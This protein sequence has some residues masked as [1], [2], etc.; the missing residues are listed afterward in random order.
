MGMQVSNSMIAAKA[1]SDATKDVNK[2]SERIATG[3]RVNRAADDP[4]ALSQ[5]NKLKA[6]ISSFDRVKTN[7]SESNSLLSQV[8]GSLSQISSILV[9]MKDLAN[10]SA[11]ENDA[12][13]RANYQAAFASYLEDIN[14]IASGTLLDGSSILDG[15]RNPNTAVIQVGI[16]AS[17]TKTLTFFDSSTTGLS[18][19]SLNISSTAGAGDAITAL[20]SA[21]DTTAS[22][23]STVGAYQNS[24]SIIGD[25]VDSSVLNKTLQYQGLMNA[26]LAAETANLAAAQIRQDAASAML[27]QSFRLDRNLVNYLLHSKD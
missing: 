7:L 10:L 14:S 5:A 3:L 17:D 20:G 9:E 22:R 16:N 8:D 21:I 19:A 24:I 18:I 2:A 25:F 6:E 1:I 12:T 27:A 26:D 13:I 4:G 23:L 15:S 11:S